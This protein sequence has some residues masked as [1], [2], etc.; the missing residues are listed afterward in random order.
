MSFRI[1]SASTLFCAGLII[2]TA[3]TL[4]VTY[5]FSLSAAEEI[6]QA[7]A[8]AQAAKAKDNAEVFVNRPAELI[9]EPQTPRGD[10]S[11][12]REAKPKPEAFRRTSHARYTDAMERAISSIEKKSARIMSANKFITHRGFQADDLLQRILAKCQGHLEDL[13]SVD[14]AIIWRKRCVVFFGTIGNDL[15]VAI[16]DPHGVPD[17]DVG[18]TKIQTLHLLSKNDSAPSATEGVAATKPL[19]EAF[20]VYCVADGVAMLTQKNY[21]VIT[22][23]VAGALMALQKHTT[24]LASPHDALKPEFFCQLEPLKVDGRVV[25]YVAMSGDDWTALNDRFVDC[26]LGRGR[27]SGASTLFDLK[28]PHTWAELSSVVLIGGESGSGKT[29]E[30]LCGHC[31][32]SDLAV[33]MRFNP[34][35]LNTIHAQRVKTISDND[36]IVNDSTVADNSRHAAR[37]KRNREFLELTASVVRCALDDSCPA[38]VEPLKNHNSETT[39]TVRLCFDEMGSSPAFVRACCAINVDALREKLGWGTSVKIFVVAAGTGIGTVLNPGGSENTRYH[40]SM[41]TLSDTPHE[42][43]VYWKL[44]QHLLKNRTMGTGPEHPLVAVLESNVAAIGVNWNDRKKRCEKLQERSVTLSA[45]FKAHAADKRAKSLRNQSKSDDRDKDPLSALIAR[46]AL[47]AAVESDGACA[48]AL[49]NARMGALFVSVVQEV[50]KHTI[51]HELSVVTSGTNI[52]R[53]VLQRVARIFRSLNGLKGISPQEAS[54]LLVESLRYALFDGYGGRR[55]SVD[56]LVSGRG[57]LVDNAVYR[58]KVP[59]SYEVLYNENQPI[60]KKIID[61]DTKTD[62]TYTACY[63]KEVGRFS[64]SPA[65]VVVLSALMSNAFEENFS[66]IGDVFERDMAKFLYLT[67]Q[68]FHGRPLSELVDFIVGPLA[69]VGEAA[70]AILDGNRK[71]TFDLLTLRISGSVK[72]GAKMNANVPREDAGDNGAPQQ[73]DREENDSRSTSDSERDDEGWENDERAFPAVKIA[74]NAKGDVVTS[75]SED[76]ELWSTTSGGAWIEISPPRLA[77]ADIVLH[78]PNVITLPIQ[79][80]DRVGVFPY[81]VVGRSMNKMLVEGKRWRDPDPTKKMRPEATYT[82][83][84]KDFDKVFFDVETAAAPDALADLEPTI[85]G[86]SESMLS[87]NIVE[88]DLSEDRA[89][90]ATNP[91]FAT[92]KQK[93]RQKPSPI[94]YGQKLSNLGVPVIPILYVSHAHTISSSE[95]MSW[96]HLYAIGPHCIMAEGIGEHSLKLPQLLLTMPPPVPDAV[97][98]HDGTMLNDNVLP[99]DGAP[100]DEQRTIE[101]LHRVRR[102]IMLFEF[103]QEDPTSAVDLAVAPAPAVTKQ[104]G[105]YSGGQCTV[106]SATW[107]RHLSGSSRNAAKTR[108]LRNLKLKEILRRERIDLVDKLVQQISSTKLP[109]PAAVAQSASKFNKVPSSL[110]ELNQAKQDIVM[111]LDRTLDSDKVRAIQKKGLDNNTFDESLDE[112]VIALM[113]RGA[114]GDSAN[115]QHD[116]QKLNN[117]ERENRATA[118]QKHPSEGPSGHRGKKGGC[119]NFRKKQ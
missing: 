13:T 78:I 106:F 6:A 92:L 8:F 85:G 37:S 58:R 81:Q 62:T 70:Q 71:V 96:D 77:S 79:C 118:T 87:T 83:L 53:S 23:F 93:K 25:R 21:D 91:N 80:K 89:A 43:S 56:E 65:M 24:V 116:E 30:M 47:F 27:L 50:A 36:D 98:T 75:A 55:F 115:T 113:R 60:T 22:D 94:D 102:S 76:I 84:K 26:H 41:L 33:Y 74:G 5:S 90:A 68:V 51:D 42:S 114:T 64:I 72:Q 52:R 63:P 108:I 95:S 101:R 119:R 104:G 9:S 1:R 117:D 86:G 19:H 16:A 14:N 4:G 88:E 112:D 38:I 44:R 17:A 35:V 67:V 54:A 66:N 15:F 29:I 46:E 99:L 20:E 7:H 105:I 107:R 3:A 82:D 40:L 109:P 59:A 69:L 39:F 57:V 28:L 11:A 61:N 12:H 10:E 48:A 18:V 2:I 45:L 31:D 73:S 97:P 103:R 34:E 110:E 100:L 111:R 32:K 49:S